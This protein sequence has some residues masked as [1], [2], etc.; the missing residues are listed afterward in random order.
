MPSTPPPYESPSPERSEAG[1]AAE[2]ETGAEAG[3]GAEAGSD[4]DGSGSVVFTPLGPEPDLP[5]WPRNFLAPKSL[6]NKAARLAAMA[7][8]QGETHG[9]SLQDPSNADTTA[10][11]NDNANDNSQSQGQSVDQGPSE[12][13]IEPT[14]DAAENARLRTENERLKTEMEKL[15]DLDTD[16]ISQQIDLE[17]AQE[18]KA[19]L[20]RQLEQ[21]T[22]E[23]DRAIFNQSSAEA[24]ADMEMTR[25]RNREADLES[26][27][28]EAHE[29]TNSNKADIA[30]L[31]SE[32]ERSQGKVSVL[33]GRV[34]QFMTREEEIV[35]EGKTEISKREETIKSYEDEIRR[36]DGEANQKDEE[37]RRRDEELKN[38]EEEFK[39]LRHDENYN[40]D[41]YSNANRLLTEKNLEIEDKDK[42][43]LQL[44]D[45]VKGLRAQLD[46]AKNGA[47]QPQSTE[48]DSKDAEIQ[49][50]KDKLARE[51][52]RIDNAV[53][54]MRKRNNDVAS[55][56]A[57]IVELEKSVKDLTQKLSAADEAI[58]KDNSRKSEKDA[59]IARLRALKKSLESDLEASSQSVKAKE[60]DIAAKDSQIQTLRQE[61]DRLKEQLAQ[62]KP[63]EQEQAQ[64]ASD[65]ESKNASLARASS[66]KDNDLAAAKRDLATSKSDLVSKESQLEAKKAKIKELKDKLMLL[67]PQL[68]QAER[69]KG[70]L[71][72]K[73]KAMSRDIAEAKG[74][75][76]ALKAKAKAKEAAEAK[77][78]AGTEVRGN[79]EAQEKT[80]VAE[81]AEARVRVL[82]AEV[83][84]LKKKAE[85]EANAKS[86][87]ERPSNPTRQG[88]NFD[89][90][91]L[92]GMSPSDPESENSVGSLV[93][94]ELE[95]IDV[96]RQ[97]KRMDSDGELISLFTDST[98]EFSSGLQDFA[99]RQLAEASKQARRA[100]QVRQVF[101]SLMRRGDEITGLTLRLAGLRKEL[102]E[103][104]VRCRI[105]QNKQNEL[106]QYQKGRKMVEAITRVS[107]LLPE[108]PKDLKELERLIDNIKAD[109]RNVRNM[110]EEKDAVNKEWQGPDLDELLIR[111][112]EKQA[113]ASATGTEP[114]TIRQRDP[115]AASLEAMNNQLLG[116]VEELVKSLTKA[117]TDT[118]QLEHRLK[119]VSQYIAPELSDDEVN[120]A[121][122]QSD[123]E[124]FVASSDRIPPLLGWRLFWGVALL[125]FVAATWLQ[126]DK[127]HLWQVANGF[128]RRAWVNSAYPRVM[129]PDPRYWSLYVDAD[130]RGW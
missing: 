8:A 57:K 94:R 48:G 18:D 126:L 41:Q 80:E 49:E 101:Y 74:R 111:L 5:S 77:Q 59:S 19:A 109:H 55:R 30:A 47:Q 54:W 68:D 32:L 114:M 12:S 16:M 10:N 4:S 89:Q 115:S 100:K 23:R 124:H 113:P 105:L 108:I 107:A 28:L 104:Q 21:A 106:Q 2:A 63:R 117:E 96:P 53:A 37:F 52:Q 103:Q 67:Q 29:T 69:D 44:Q 73:V 38:Q 95:P 1:N 42:D 72:T 118:V 22:A 82:E 122:S 17:Q 93:G 78:D 87:T 64:K 60:T 34:F 50:L 51:E 130:M 70:A 9:Q 56:T 7:Q 15:N 75:E 6:R 33:E 35:S 92:P 20:Q 88:L 13:A 98:M 127:Y 43:I 3:G 25:W 62:V 45:T 99:G 121:R 116:S 11:A 129:F 120:K 110:L 36:R 79:T 46:Q 102:R 123:E 83:E 40:I 27:L 39:R 85:A 90:P 71:S 91:G 61:I 125:V 58:E 97:H 76:E 112:G 128:S 26:K 119:T 65:L 84:A 81:K 66:A 31:K 14:T 86:A 24:E